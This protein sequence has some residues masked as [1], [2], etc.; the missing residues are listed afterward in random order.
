MTLKRQTDDEVQSKEVPKPFMTL[1][2][3]TI[4]KVT[5]SF[6]YMGPGQPFV[7]RHSSDCV[8]LNDGKCENVGGFSV[9]K[10]HAGFYEKIWMKYGHIASNKVLKDSYAQVPVV[11]GI[12]DTIVHMHYC[13]FP[14]LTSRIIERWEDNIK[15][16]EKLEFN[17]GWVRDWLEYVKKVFSG[18]EKL[19]AAF[20]QQDELLQAEKKKSVEAKNAYEEAEKSIVALETKMSLLIREKQEYEEKDSHLLS[21]EWLQ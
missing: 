21:L 18:K 8:V 3:E 9:L 20:I 4:D 13:R 5:S 16:A 15:N 19:A 1:K 11:S 6:E 17:I 10:S 12:M 14:E 2:R 7:G